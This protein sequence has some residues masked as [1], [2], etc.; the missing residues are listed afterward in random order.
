MLE[1]PAITKT[2]ETGY[3]YSSKRHEVG[4]DPLGNVVNAGDEILVLDDEF[5]LV[6]GL[7]SDSIEILENHGAVYKM[8]K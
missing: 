2:R 1:H 6:N 3:P 5:Y 4:I 8:A 7:I